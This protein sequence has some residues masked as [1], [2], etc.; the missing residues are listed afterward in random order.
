ML[1]DQVRD[2]LVHGER[3]RSLDSDLGEGG[4]GHPLADIIPDPNQE[5][6]DVAF[7]RASEQ[8][9]WERILLILSDRERYVIR[10]YFGFGGEEPNTLEEI[11]ITVGLT[12]ERVRQIKEKALAKLMYGSRSEELRA[13]AGE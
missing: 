6:P 5:L 10:L 9:R 13:L 7:E 11:G 4:E 1:V 3:V 8:A 2:I 12:R